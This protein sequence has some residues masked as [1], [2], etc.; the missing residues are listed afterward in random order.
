[1]KRKKKNK[2]KISVRLL[3]IGSILLVSFCFNCQKSSAIGHITSD[4]HGTTTEGKEIALQDLT[5]NGFVVNFY[6]PICVPCVKEI[7]ALELLYKQAEQ[8]N[9]PMRILV[10]SELLDSM[11][12]T[13]VDSVS[14]RREKI[15][16]LREDAQ[17]RGILVPV[18]LLAE[19]IKIAE[20]SIEGTPETIYF[21]GVGERSPVYNFIGPITFQQEPTQIRQDARFQ[22]ALDQLK[23]L[24]P[25]IA[26]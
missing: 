15:E 23:K 17:R 22:F 25:S 18:I 6:S 12:A 7:P 14:L 9:T 1:M 5:G 24:A 16:I 4:W 13:N 21:Q 19:E 2:K 3:Y 20:S 10:F 8:Q 11:V 26:L